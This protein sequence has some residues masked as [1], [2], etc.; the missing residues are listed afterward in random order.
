MKQNQ[1]VPRNSQT[2]GSNTKHVLGMSTPYSTR[3]SEDTH[4]SSRKAQIFPVTTASDPRNSCLENFR[5]D[6]RQEGYH[7]LAF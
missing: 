5:A 4:G 1:P 3:D 2:A 7:Q 6:V